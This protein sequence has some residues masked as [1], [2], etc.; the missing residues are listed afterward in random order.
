[1]ALARSQRERGTTWGK[2]VRVPAVLSGQVSE[3]T[4][5]IAISRPALSKRAW[6]RATIRPSEAAPME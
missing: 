4:A 2:N 5:A 1:M 6:P 3:L